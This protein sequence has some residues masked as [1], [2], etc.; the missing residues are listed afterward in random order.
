[1]IKYLRNFVEN[2]VE[3]RASPDSYVALFSEDM[4]N[5][6]LLRYLGTLSYNIVLISRDRKNQLQNEANVRITWGGFKK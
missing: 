5:K 3:T 2:L 1:M 4:I 6:R